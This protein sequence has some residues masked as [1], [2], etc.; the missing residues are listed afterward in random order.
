MKRRRTNAVVPAALTA[1]VLL[2][3][4]LAADPARAASTASTS[5]S[6]QTFDYSLSTSSDIPV[7][8]PNATTPQVVASLP[9]GTIVPPKQ[10]D[11]TQGS[12]LTILNSSTGFDQNQLVVALK[13]D[14]TNGSSQQLFGLSFFG[15]GLKAAGHLDF[16][17]NVDKSLSMAP[18]LTSQTPGVTIKSLEVAAPPPSTI[19]NP[20]AGTPQPHTQV[21]EPIS[22]ILWSA[23][24]GAGFWRWRKRA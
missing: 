9:A 1:A 8:D 24:A 4:G 21:P 16:A 18:V 19:L 13:D 12:P 23:L 5:I 17:L 15:S 11:G 3:L 7:P 20:S 10:S 2:V 14:V 6:T 22:L